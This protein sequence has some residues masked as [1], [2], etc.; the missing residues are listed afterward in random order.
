MFSGTAHV[1][2]QVC[3]IFVSSVFPL[4]PV[5]MVDKNK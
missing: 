5:N 1:S 2:H 4:V 3:R